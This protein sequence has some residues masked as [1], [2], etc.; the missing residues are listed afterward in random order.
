AKL[1]AILRERQVP[2]DVIARLKPWAALTNLTVTPED[3][4]RAT[5]DQKLV[6]LARERKLRV[7]GLEGVEE[8]ISVFDRIPLDTQV[9]LLKPA[10]DRRAEFGAMI[11]PPIRAWMNRDPAGIRAASLRAGERYPEVAEHYRILHTRVVENRS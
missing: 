11:E 7:L 4:E 6:E 10:L 3:Y 8:Q 2:D 5:L 9:Q 1:V